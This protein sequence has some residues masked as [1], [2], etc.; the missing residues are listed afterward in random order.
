M[1]SKHGPTEQQNSTKVNGKWTTSTDKVSPLMLT[2][3]STSVNGKKASGTDKVSPLMPT[4]LST[5]ELSKM[6]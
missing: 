1:V 6:I 2:E 4:D 5:K 3:V